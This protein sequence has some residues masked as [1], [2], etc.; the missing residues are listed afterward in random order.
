MSSST[1]QTVVVLGSGIVGLS[2]CYYLLRLSPSSKVVLVENSPSR[3]IAG[4]AS[5]Y[6]GGF[7]AGGETW[8][9]GHEGALRMLS[10]ACH[11]EMAA[12]LDGGEKWGFRHCGVIGLNVGGLDEDRSKY[13]NLPQ[14]AGRKAVEGDGKEL[15]KGTWV[16]GEREELSTEGGVGQVDP[17][18]FCRTVFQHLTSTYPG[19]FQVVFGQATGLSRS[20][21]SSNR[22]LAI[23]P[24]A[25]SSSSSAPSPVT[26]SFNKLVVAA[27]PWSGEVCK[28]LGLPAI[29]LTNLPG[30]SLLIRPSL[31]GYQG[32]SELPSEAVFAGI[33]GAVGGVHASTSG[34]ARGLTEE[35]KK[36]G[37]TRS[38]EMFVRKNGIIF[39]AGENRIPETNPARDHL[40][41]KLPPTVDGVKNLLDQNLINRL[42]R[43]AGA[44]SPLLKEENGAIIEAEQF[45]YRPVFPDR[46]PAVGELEPGVIL[47]TGHGPWGIALAPGTGKVVAELALGQPLS[48]DIKALSPNRFNIPKA[49][50]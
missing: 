50:L 17:A 49:K 7:I 47:A 42:K 33:A 22:K 15:P 25:D 35:E 6:A 29:P 32:G 20:W 2:T 19:R 36:E 12:H 4:G 8:N 10:F 31:S 46:E 24:T 44:V 26:L 48:A 40:D 14:G 39:V 28:Q 30:H 27:G 34:L 13:R 41:N 45:C 23:Q 21:F 16:E 43:A 5:S 9:D 3:T 11:E 37:Y 38:P 1:Q 18:Q